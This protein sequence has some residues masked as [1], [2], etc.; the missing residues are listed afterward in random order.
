MANLR[1]RADP[2]DRPRARR[3]S[4]RRQPAADRHPD[5][6]LLADRGGRGHDLGSRSNRAYAEIMRAR[7]AMPVSYRDMAAAYPDL[8]ETAR[9]AETAMQRENPTQTPIEIFLIGV[10][11]GFLALAYR[12]AGSRG[13]AGAVAVRP[14][15]DRPGGMA[16][17]SGS[18]MSR[19]WA[20]PRRSLPV[21]HLPIRR[22]PST[23][24][25]PLWRLLYCRRL[26]H[27]LR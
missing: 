3:Q 19:S 5:Q 9:A 27:R 26:R 16:A 7:G 20:I 22:R 6:R 18:A 14:G 1:G 13:P 24:G 2:D 25:S 11:V 4:R 21:C 23:T 17:P 15:A 10:C 12:R 8:F